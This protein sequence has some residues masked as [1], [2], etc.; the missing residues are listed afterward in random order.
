MKPSDLQQ[1][2]KQYTLIKENADGEE[3][4]MMSAEECYEAYAAI[5]REMGEVLQHARE[6]AGKMQALIDSPV[7]Q[8]FTNLDWPGLDEDKVGIIYT[9]FGA[10]GEDYIDS[11][12]NALR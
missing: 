9:D 10:W 3:E 12:K 6:I 2:F 5:D 8:A 4:Q 7:F 1:L 11:F